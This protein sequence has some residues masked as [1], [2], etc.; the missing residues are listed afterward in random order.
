[1][2]N[3]AKMN[4]ADSRRHLKIGKKAAENAKLVQTVSTFSVEPALFS[5]ILS[6]GL[7]QHQAGH[8]PEAERSY[9][10]VLQ[11]DPDQPVALHYLGIIASQRGDLD[12]AVNL[13]TKSV[14]AEPNYDQA[15]YNLGNA[16]RDLKMLEEAITSYHNAIAISP[17]AV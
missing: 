9:K 5:K 2:E 17:Q 7:Q 4:R 11:A 10:Q 15:H 1:M 14:T 13:M 16:L 8:L 3:C 12:L 6:A